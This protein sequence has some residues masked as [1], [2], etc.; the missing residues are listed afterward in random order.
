MKDLPRNAPCPC[1]SGRKYKHCC[2]RKDEAEAARGDEKDE[3]IDGPPFPLHLLPP[4]DEVLDDLDDPDSDEVG[5]SWDEDDG[6]DEGWDDDDDDGDEDDLDL[7][8][9]DLSGL[10]KIGEINDVGYDAEVGPIGD[11]WRDLDSDERG[12]LV[13]AYHWRIGDLLPER[14]AREMHNAIHATVETQVL[15]GEPPEAKE[16]LDRLRTAGIPRHA[17]IHAIGEVMATTIFDVLKQGKDGAGTYERG[18]AAI[19]PQRWLD[20]LA[21]E[22]DEEDDETTTGRTTT[23]SS[24]WTTTRSSSRTSPPTTRSTGSRTTPTGHPTRSAGRPCPTSPSASPSPPTTVGSTTR[25]RAKTSA[26]NMGSC[27]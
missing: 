3:K 21:D 20:A 5:A 11:G 2:L 14:A 15:T 7:D 23:G 10:E 19:D 24:C 22:E 27:T 4:I 12:L 26:C 9:G 6:W 18:L 1:G 25:W 16:A 13:A 8:D 17:A